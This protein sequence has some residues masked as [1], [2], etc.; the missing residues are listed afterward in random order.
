[1]IRRAVP[2]LRHRGTTHEIATERVTIE[3][4]DLRAPGAPRAR[5]RP[6]R[7]LVLRAARVAEEG[8]AARRHVPAE[9]PLHVPVHGEARGLLRDDPARPEGARDLAPAA[10]EPARQPALPETA[11]RYNQPFVLEDVAAQIGYRCT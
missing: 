5:D 11:A 1:M 9:Q 8:R 7:L 4:F 10:Q 6:P 3:P 2:S